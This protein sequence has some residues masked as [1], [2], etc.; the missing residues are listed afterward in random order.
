[1]WIEDEFNAVDDYLGAFNVNAKKQT[2]ALADM[3]APA[4]ERFK[5]CQKA[6]R[7]SS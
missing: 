3:M 4:E 6:I 1:M 2:K 5:A 7:D